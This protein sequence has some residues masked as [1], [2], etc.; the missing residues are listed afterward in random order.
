[1]TARQTIESLE[2]K[3]L[4]QLHHSGLVRRK[5]RDMRHRDTG[6]Q[7]RQCDQEAG[8]RSRDPDVEQAP[9]VNDRGVH[10]DEG[11]KGPDDHGW[12]RRDEVWKRYPDPVPLCCEI[13]AHLVDNQD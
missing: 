11:A 3:R 4:A 12:R 10:P 9:P 7:R 2:E 8:N 1:M 13:M 5:L 6:E